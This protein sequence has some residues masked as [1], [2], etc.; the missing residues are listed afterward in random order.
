M[1]KPDL[2]LLQHGAEQEAAGAGRLIDAGVG[3]LLL[4]DQ[5]QQVALDLLGI[6]RS[7]EQ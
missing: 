5:V 7:G 1:S 6:S 2:A 4:G 3:E